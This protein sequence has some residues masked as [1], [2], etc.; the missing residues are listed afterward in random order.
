MDKDWAS[1][2]GYLMRNFTGVY[3]YIIN[4]GIDAKDINK[5]RPTLMAIAASIAPISGFLSNMN[6]VGEFKV[7][8]VHVSKGVTALSKSIYR[9]SLLFIRLA[10]SNN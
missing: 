6:S 3:R 7:D 5:Y 1:T 9:S 8:L 2:V 4:E 10:P